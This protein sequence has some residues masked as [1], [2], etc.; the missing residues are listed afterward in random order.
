MRLWCGMNQEPGTMKLLIF[1][2]TSQFL[3]TEKCLYQNTAKQHHW[4]NTVNT[5]SDVW[6][7]FYVL[8][9]FTAS[10]CASLQSHSQCEA[11][12]SLVGQFL[13]QI[14]PDRLQR[15]FE[16][17]DWLWFCLELLIGLQHRTLD[18]A[19][20][21]SGEFGGNWWFLMNSEQLTW[22]HSCVMHVCH[23]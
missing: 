1:F 18:M 23:W 20:H 22:N 21:G 12:N 16:F 4:N 19:V 6:Q 15:F 7:S 13:W 14:F 9:L 2:S 3:H 11:F 8:E 17:S 5:S 10:F